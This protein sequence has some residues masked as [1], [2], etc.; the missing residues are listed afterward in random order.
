MI[1]TAELRKL[2]ETAEKYWAL[3]FKAEFIPQEIRNDY[4]KFDAAANGRTI[5]ELLD[6]L[7]AAEKVCNLLDTVLNKNGNESMTATI[8][9]YGAHK[10]WQEVAK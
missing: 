3:F 5:V 6:R 9:M 8:K 1:D 2:A 7:D 10:E 4:A